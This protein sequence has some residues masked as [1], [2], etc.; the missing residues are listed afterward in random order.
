M[1]ESYVKEKIKNLLKARKVWYFM[2]AMGQFGRAGV[3]DFICCVRGRLLAIEAKVGGNIPTELQYRE[4]EN[5]NTAQ[6][7]AVVVNEHR[8]DALAR[9]I[10]SMLESPYTTYTVE[11][12]M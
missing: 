3:P 5:I 2:P 11:G 7:I 4:I 6:G 1:K 8:L 12:F 9:L 10:D